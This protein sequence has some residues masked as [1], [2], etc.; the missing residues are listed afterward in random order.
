M[1]ELDPPHELLVCLAVERHGAQDWQQ[2]AAATDPVLVA[3]GYQSSSESLGPAQCEELFKTHSSSVGTAGALSQLVGELV[4]RRTAYL[5]ATSSALKAHLAT[6]GGGADGGGDIAKAR[7]G[8]SS[9][10]RTRTA[11]AETLGPDAEGVESWVELAEEVCAWALRTPLTRRLHPGPGPPPPR[12]ASA[13]PRPPGGALSRHPPLPPPPR[14]RR[15][16]F[17]RRTRAAPTC[18][19]RCSSSSSR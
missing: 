3:L 16:T 7:A 9:V 8:P 17:R 13:L 18:R 10:G 2:I 4:A 15:P 6:G 19:A 12:L 1:A 11:P 14:N 5:T